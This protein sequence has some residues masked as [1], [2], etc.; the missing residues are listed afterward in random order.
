MSKPFLPTCL[1]NFHLSCLER[2]HLLFQ[3]CNLTFDFAQLRLILCAPGLP[4]RIFD[5]R[6]PDILTVNAEDHV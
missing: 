2:A 4:Q 3:R 6:L 1:L 5:N